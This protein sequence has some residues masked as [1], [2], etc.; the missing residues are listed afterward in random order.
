MPMYNVYK[1]SYIVTFGSL[2]IHSEA[3]TCMN[4]YL[5]LLPYMLTFWKSLEGD[6]PLSNSKKRE[7]L[8]RHFLQPYFFFFEDGKVLAG[9]ENNLFLPDIV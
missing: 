1:C 5:C 4:L 7:I 2:P 9:P 8:R 6:L 3:L